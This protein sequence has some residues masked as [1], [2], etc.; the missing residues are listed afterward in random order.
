MGG[1]EKKEVSQTLK[2]L[3]ARYDNIHKLVRTKE[4]ELEEAKKKL[5]GMGEEELNIEDSKTRKDMTL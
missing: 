4:K 5:E 2:K 3:R 1:E